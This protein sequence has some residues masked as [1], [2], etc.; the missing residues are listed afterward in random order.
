MICY[1]IV[2]VQIV[3]KAS[4]SLLALAKN[5]CNLEVAAFMSCDELALKFYMS[6]CNLD[7]S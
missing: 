6:M 4:L 1:V 2:T 7:V 5:I 3:S